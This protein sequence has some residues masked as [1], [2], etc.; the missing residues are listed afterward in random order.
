MCDS[1]GSEW[2]S[3][4]KTRNFLRDWLRIAAAS[5]GFVHTWCLAEFMAI[6]TGEVVRNHWIWEFHGDI[7]RQIHPLGSFEPSSAS[8]GQ[9]T[10]ESND[11]STIDT[12]MTSLV[13]SR[14]LKFCFSWTL[15]IYTSLCY[16]VCLKHFFWNTNWAMTNRN[17]RNYP[18]WFMDLF[19][20]LI[21]NPV[22]EVFLV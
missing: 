18:G 5:V 22:T 14:V 6:V 15:T 12:P 4:K 9:H 16:T 1:G 20:C 13:Q 17:S 3:E 10:L 8:V 2:K 11:Q 21:E 7:F 19:R